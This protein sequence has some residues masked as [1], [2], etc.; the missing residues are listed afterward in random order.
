LMDFKESINVLSVLIKGL[1]CFTC[2]LTSL[3]ICDLIPRTTAT[4]T[5]PCKSVTQCH[6]GNF[7]HSF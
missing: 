5:S 6:N 2:H 4:F 3:F 7:S 1:S